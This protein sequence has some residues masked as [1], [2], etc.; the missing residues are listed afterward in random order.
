MWGRIGSTGSWV[1]V[2][3][4]VVVAFPRILEEFDRVWLADRVL[5][6]TDIPKVSKN[7]DYKEI[8]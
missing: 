5:M 3:V 2:V 6:I 8:G 7:I 1:V 4:V